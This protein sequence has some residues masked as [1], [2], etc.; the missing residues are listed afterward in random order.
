MRYSIS[1]GLF[2]E[3]IADNHYVLIPV[4]GPR[5][6]TCYVH[7]NSFERRTDDVLLQRPSRSSPRSLDRRTSCTFLAPALGVFSAKYL[8]KSLP[9]FRKRLVDSKTSTRTPSVYFSKYFL[10]S[11]GR[12]HQLH[13]G[14]RAT[15]YI[16]Y[17][18]MKQ[19]TYDFGDNF[20]FPYNHPLHQR[21]CAI[22]S[23]MNLCP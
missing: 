8:V 14:T 18:T 2:D 23:P 16:F 11:G 22:Y 12:N 9:N 5:E 15:K 20:I 10:N 19:K 21:T 17:L 3:A 6:R 13:V 1:F 4:F 7:C